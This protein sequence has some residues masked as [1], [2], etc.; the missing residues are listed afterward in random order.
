[1]P[2]CYRAAGRH[3]CLTGEVPVRK[4]VGTYVILPYIKQQGISCLEAVVLTHTDQ[5]HINGVT[6]V[7]EEGKKRLADSKKSYV[8]ILDGRDGTGK[9]TEKAGRR[10]GSLL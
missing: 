2:A 10:S 7:L 3:F 6:E 5:D 4:N 1:M 9:T 8:S